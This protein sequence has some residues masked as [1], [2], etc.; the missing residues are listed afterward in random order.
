[1]TIES[2][3][4]AEETV[5][6]AS[7]EVEDW[8]DPTPTDPDAL[9]VLLLGRRLLRAEGVAHVECVAAASRLG[10]APEPLIVTNVVLRVHRHYR[11]LATPSTMTLAGG[12]IAGRR[13]LTSRNPMLTPGHHY[14]AFFALEVGGDVKLLEVLDSD[15]T[16]AVALGGVTLEAAQISQVVEETP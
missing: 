14:L 3:A 15:E 10:V 8:I 4:A 6:I 2:G 16:G 11:G 13:M 7:D 5:T 1:M 9:A 12:E